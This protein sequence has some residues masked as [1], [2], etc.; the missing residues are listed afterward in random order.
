MARLLSART[1]FR[2]TY[3][4]STA[5][6]GKQAV[7]N[8]YAMKPGIDSLLARLADRVFTGVSAAKPVAGGQAHQLQFIPAIPPVRLTSWQDYRVSSRFGWRIHPIGGDARLHN[9]M[10]I[11]QPAGTPVYATAGGVVKWVTWEVD[12]LGLAVCVEHPTGYQSI[13]G[14]LSAYAVRKGDVVQR[15]TLL[16]QV[17]STGRSTGPHLHYAILYRGKPV[18]PERYCFLWMKLAQARLSQTQGHRSVEPGVL[19]KREPTSNKHN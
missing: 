19:P 11:P 7:T 9:G 18:D 17:G 1:S 8:V 12:G 4:D 16:G 3:F 14:H 15:G 6:M 2:V 10:D 13:Y 5:R